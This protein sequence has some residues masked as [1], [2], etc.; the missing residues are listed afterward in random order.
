LAFCLSDAQCRLVLNQLQPLFSQSYRLKFP[1]RS[2]A[3][4]AACPHS[5]ILG[6]SKIAQVEANVL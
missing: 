3:K 6:G 2:A 1:P 5:F 4:V